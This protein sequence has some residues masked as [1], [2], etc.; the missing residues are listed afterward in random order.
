M[1]FFEVQGPALQDELSREMAALLLQSTESQE[2]RLARDGIAYTLEEFL[3]AYGHEGY[4]FWA[5]ATVA[6]EIQERR[7][8]WDGIAYTLE[9]F[10]EAYGHEG[11]EFWAYATVA[12]EHGAPQAAAVPQAAPQAAAAPQAPPQAAPPV[13][14]TAADVDNLRAA[15]ERIKPPRSLHTLARDTLNDMITAGVNGDIDR[16]LEQWFP[17]RNYIACHVK[18]YEIIGTGVT[19]AMAEYIPQTRD[20]NRGYQERL[21]FVI[22]RTDATRCRLHPGKRPSQDAKLIFD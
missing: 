7:L 17:W 15:E 2:R 3:D 16:N 9:E 14:L 4:D 22:Y 11:Y 12:T 20:S 10:L 18:A 19:H 1:S 5:N 8:A 13:L 21:D 6:T